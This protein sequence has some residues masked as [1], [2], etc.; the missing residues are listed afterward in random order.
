VKQ[1]FQAAWVTRLESGTVPQVTSKLRGARADGADGRCCLGVLCDLA[2]A[3]GVGRWEYKSTSDGGDR[4]VFVCGD[5]DPEATD[6]EADESWSELPAPVR[7]WAGLA[8]DEANPFTNQ[9]TETMGPT[10]APLTLAELN[11]GGWTFANIASVIRT[12][13]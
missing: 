3:A 8:I 5:V 12:D 6:T 2:E 7:R 1:D 13:L 10:S 9:R 4:W 11:D